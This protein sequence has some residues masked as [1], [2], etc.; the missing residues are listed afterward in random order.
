LK[1]KNVFEKVIYNL[2][3][4]S[5]GI[6]LLIINNDMW[7]AIEL[8]INTNEGKNYNNEKDKSRHKKNHIFIDKY[9]E[10]MLRI[11]APTKVVGDYYFYF[12]KDLKY[13]VNCINSVYKLAS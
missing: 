5:H 4:D 13:I 9:I 12:K 6:D 11:E 10:R 3:N 8:F 1:E 2:S 7:F